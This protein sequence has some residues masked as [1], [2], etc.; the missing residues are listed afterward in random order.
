MASELRGR[1]IN[2]KKN[3]LEIAGTSKSELA[4]DRRR[5]KGGLIGHISRMWGRYKSTD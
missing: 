2:H 4:Q 3:T 1:K 5:S